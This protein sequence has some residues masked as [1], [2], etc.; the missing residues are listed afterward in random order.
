MRVSSVGE[1]YADLL[2]AAG[3]DTMPELLQRKARPV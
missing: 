3:V 2:E 1:E